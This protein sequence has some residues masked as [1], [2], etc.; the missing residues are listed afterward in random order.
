MG[1]YATYNGES[2]KVGTCEDFYYLRDDQRDRID[3]YGFSEEL[4]A[5][6]RFRFP[7]PDEDD[8]E[9]GAFDDH[10]RG[11][12]V[13]GGYRLPAELSGDEHHSV[14]FT[15]QPGYLMSIPCPEGRRQ[16]GDVMSTDVDGLTVHRNGFNGGPVVRQ[17]AHRGGHLVTLLRCGACGAVHRLDTL[18]DAAPIVAAFR[19]EAEREEYGGLDGYRFAHSERER[20]HLRAIADRIEAGY[21]DPDLV[22]MDEGIRAAEGSNSVAAA[23]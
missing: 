4:L 14:Q 5:V 23:D 3:G 9:P 8:I 22:A 21:V 20:K 15:A 6:V 13:P 16:E 1:E 7:F 2:I 11:V 19:A 10:A 18:E 17:Q 12:R